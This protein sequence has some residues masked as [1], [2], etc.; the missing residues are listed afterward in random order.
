[1]CMNRP[2]TKTLVHSGN[3]I[4]TIFV[5]LENPLLQCLVWFF[6]FHLPKWLSEKMWFLFL[7]PLERWN[8][9]Q[10]WKNS[11]CW[12]FRNPA[13]QLRLV[14]YPIIYRV[15]NIPSG[16]PWD[17]WT[18]Q[19]V[20]PPENQVG[21]IPFQVNPP[22]DKILMGDALMMPPF[23]LKRHR[24][25]FQNW[26][27]VSNIFNFHPYL[28]KWSNLTN[29]FQ[30]GWNHQLE[31]DPTNLPKLFRLLSKIQVFHQDIC[32]CSRNPFLTK[33]TFLQISRFGSPFTTTFQKNHPFLPPT[34]TSPPPFP[35]RTLG[36]EWHGT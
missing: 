18:H 33:E 26:M 9:K 7:L 25:A 15:L 32:F 35:A 17:F 28:G 4:I 30:R 3:I 12:W 13:N 19:T 14:A 6:N 1:M 8:Q 16:W 20:G 5:G 29:I 23:C 21:W 10:L 11:N 22:A 2:A 27:V 31:K 36:Q 34:N 24:D